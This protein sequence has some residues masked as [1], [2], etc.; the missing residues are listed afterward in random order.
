M[1]TKPT[2]LIDETRC[3][4]NIQK[5]ADKAKR[6]N[7]VLRPHFK[8]HQ[9]LEVGHWFKE[10]GIDRITVSSLTMAEYF[11][12]DWDDITVAF[13]V[14]ILEI[15]TIN[16][17]AKKIKLKLLVESVEA[18][19]FLAAYCES[20][21]GVFVKIDVGYHRTG[22][23]PA[24]SANIHAIIDLLTASDHLNFKGFLGHAGHTY[25]CRNKQG[26]LDRHETALTILS[27]LKQQFQQSFPQ[28][29]TSLGDTPS[30]SVAEN[31]AEIDEIRPG[32]F[33]YYDLSQHQIGSNEINEIAVAMACPIVALHP[34]RNE[35]ITYG[36]GVHFAKDRLEDEE[37]GTIYGKVAAPKGNSWGELISGMYL[38][39]ISQEHGVVAVPAADFAHYKIGDML[40]IL[41]VHSCMTV[42]LMRHQ[43][44]LVLN[45]LN[46]QEIPKQ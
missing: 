7:L 31:F 36:G 35:I 40:I 2:L 46:Q 14:N 19:S 30:C 12:A 3:K 32:N 27:K 5:M 33:V 15:A 45:S 29:I 23:A 6:H 38:K 37:Y 22:L 10:V 25:D 1:I 43:D 11:S 42:D 20:Q 24:D 44:V 18:A 9:S 13:P 8:T 41:P 34:E 28:C 16:A 39:K 21:V 4:A 17:L 26:I